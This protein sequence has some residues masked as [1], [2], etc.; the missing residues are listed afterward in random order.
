MD[1]KQELMAATDE[2]RERRFERRTVLKS[3][4]AGGAALIGGGIL[5]GCGGSGT[6]ILNG[7]GVTDADVLNFALNLEYLEAEYY[8]RAVNGTGLGAGDIGSAPGAVTG[9]SAVPFSTSAY[10]Q[11]AQEIAADEL[12]HVRFL[13]AALGSAAVSRPAINLSTSFD[14]AAQAAGIG[15]AFNPFADEISFLLGAFV[16]E[17]VGVA[18]YKG[19]ARLIGNK[20]FLEA[21]AGILGVEAYHAGIIR[22]VLFNIGGAATSNAQKISDLRDSAAG[23]EKDQGIVVGGNSNLVPTDSNGI[24]YSRSTTEVLKIVY[25]GGTTSGGFYPDGMNGTIR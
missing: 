21:A 6:S 9:G 13:R 8:L 25:L 22:T 15:P 24:A 7:G 19:A 20:D 11:Y 4:L 12:A 10:Q 14:A 16:F 1:I 18:A 5:A 17:D 2:L 3:M 23:T